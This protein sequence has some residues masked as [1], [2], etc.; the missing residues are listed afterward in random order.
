MRP[1][2]KFSSN[3]TGTPIIE[4]QMGGGDLLSMLLLGPV[5]S[6]RFDDFNE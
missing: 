4:S 1:G 5:K 6:R 3:F 2:H